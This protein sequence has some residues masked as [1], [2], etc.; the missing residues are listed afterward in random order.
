MT[1]YTVTTLRSGQPR[2][3]AD[4]E[5][6]YLVTIESASSEAVPMSPW[7]PGGD[8]E[9]R[10][11]KEACLESSGEADALR[12]RQTLWA[13]AVVRALCRNFRETGDNDGLNGMAAHFA[14]TLKTLTINYAKGEI[15]ALIVE[16]YTD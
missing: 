6:E 9:A 4:T 14:P 12:I 8:V 13:K 7:I 5:H 15:R 2:P 3:Y 1:R 16:A 11:R 10:I